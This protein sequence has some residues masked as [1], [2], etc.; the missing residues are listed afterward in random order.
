MAQRVLVVGGA[1]YIGSHSVRALTDLGVEVTV[2]DDLSTGH[3]AAVSAPLILGD[4]R[5]RVALR[6][7]L[8]AS[9]PD[10]VMHFA[11]KALVGESVQHPTRYFD[12]NVGGTACLAQTMLEE[13]VN[14][15]VFSSTCAVYGQPER[16]P[17]DETQARAPLSP[18]GASKHMAEQVLEAARAQEGLQVAIL[19]YFNAAGAM[20]DGSLGESHTP[21]THL[22]PLALAAALGQRPPLRLFGD[23]YPTAD[24]TCVR[25]YVHVLDL[26]SAHIACL[27]RLMDGD[28]GDAWNVGTGAGSSNR[29]VL[30]A[31]E[32]A[33][34]R[35][36]PVIVEGRRAG[37]P[38]E[39]WADPQRI[40]RELG[41]APRF[42]ALDAI[43]ETAAQWARSP[44]F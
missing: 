8:R 13:G 44:R 5:D 34:G 27:R 36:V 19:R 12:T 30:S 39:L 9:R 15:L 14:R 37:D 41:W 3:H 31:V 16:S 20:P 33:L 22:I 2:F 32:R 26:A 23:D 18:Y 29:E 25:D 28:L 40:Q 21:E 7:A 35:P 1:G 43:V 24:G 17:L 4:V 6:A 38:A 11:A 42:A 10:A